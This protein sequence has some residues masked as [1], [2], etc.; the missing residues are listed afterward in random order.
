MRAWSDVSVK[1]EFR[2]PISALKH[3]I[4]WNATRC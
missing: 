3:K 4:L 2:R 1:R